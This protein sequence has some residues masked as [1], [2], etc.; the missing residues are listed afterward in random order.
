MIALPEN[1]FRT[2]AELRTCSV[3]VIANST[4]FFFEERALLALPAF[5]LVARRT[6][7]SGVRHEAHGSC[8][9]EV[10]AGDANTA[11]LLAA[12]RTG[13][14][15]LLRL[16]LRLD[17]DSVVLFGGE[18]VEW[19]RDGRVLAV[20]A[21][22]SWP[23]NPHQTLCRDLALLA[24]GIA[25]EAEPGTWLPQ[26][27]GAVTSVAGV[28]LFPR[29]NIR[30]AAP[31]AVGDDA[32]LLA[33][34]PAWPAQGRVQIGDEVLTYGALLDDPPRLSALVRTEARA[35]AG[36]PRVHLIPG[37]PAWIVADHA[38]DVTALRTGTEDGAAV[39]QAVVE[40]RTVSGRPATAVVMERLPFEVRH[41]PLPTI[42]ATTPDAA[43]WAIDGASTA[44][45][46]AEAF[47]EDDA[48]FFFPTAPLL[49]ADW[50]RDVLLESVRHALLLRLVLAFEIDTNAFWQEGTVLRV[51]LSRAGRTVVHDFTG[52]DE[53]AN[54]VPETLS[55]VEVEVDASGLFDA[56]PA[57]EVLS[58]GSGLLTV[59]FELVN[60]HAALALSLSHVQWKAEIRA[61]TYA[62][63][64][65]HLFADVTGRTA[66]AD[67]L[68]D[69]A[70]VLE[71]LLLHADF[72][73]LGTESLNAAELAVIS[74]R[75]AL[76]GR[77]FR[78]LIASS[79]T[80]QTAV[81]AALTEAGASL[82]PRGGQWA[83]VDA[84]SPA[85]L[86]ADA[87]LAHAALLEFPEAEIG[88]PAPLRGETLSLIDEDGAVAAQVALGNGDGTVRVG[89]RWLAAGAESLATALASEFTAARR[90]QQVTLAPEW[91]AL[92]CGT[93]VNLAAPWGPE[94]VR[95]RVTAQSLGRDGRLRAE[96]TE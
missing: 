54:E 93:T 63:P 48:A 3:E 75:A 21:R 53:G 34:V 20:E 5:S 6:W 69:P 4:A 79:E 62:E 49:I 13:D 84:E 56:E 72:A 38:A 35:H 95:A 8:R 18:V 76:Q 58:P 32:I 28:P 88:A 55:N 19:Q 43:D 86:P 94:T 64:T 68:C 30:A 41:A 36:R 15:A 16:S 66:E 47:S 44:L 73:E 61:A 7:N 80:L 50:N 1:R 46:P 82:V 23:W 45:D 27:F 14:E 60:A 2:F 85:A 40:P 96:I 90:A 87:T 91:M 17:D 74:A 52:L 92:G 31:I 24:E 78:R 65:T 70:E 89:V 11:A 29:Q 57:W 59:R 42:F 12:L 77:R 26:V 71:E 22:V 51:T 10:A 83:V 25:A 37:E 9:V 81:L 67:G 33:A 39:T